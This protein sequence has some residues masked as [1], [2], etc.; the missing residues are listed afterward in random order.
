MKVF[1]FKIGNELAKKERWKKNVYE[2]IV[3]RHGIIIP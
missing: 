2:L 1:D 3:I